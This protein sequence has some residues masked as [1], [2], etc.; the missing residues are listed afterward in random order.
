MLDLRVLYGQIVPCLTVI[1][2][3]FREG[4]SLNYLVFDVESIGLHGEGFAVGWVIIDES[5]KEYE[6]GYLACPAEVARGTH[7]DFLWVQENVLPHLPE[8]T[9]I[10]PNRVRQKFW[11]KWLEVK[12]SVSLFADCGWPVEDNFLS[13]CTKQHP[14]SIAQAHYHRTRNYPGLP[15]PVLTISHQNFNGLYSRISQRCKSMPA[16]NKVD[17]AVWLSDDFYHVYL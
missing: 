5:L 14:D 10:S 7:E 6:S 2:L 3:T 17:R 13:A 12:D 8:P 15:L 1:L 16:V 11:D 9:E 4:N